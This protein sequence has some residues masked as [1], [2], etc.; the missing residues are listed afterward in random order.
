MSF[1]VLP[2]VLQDLVLDFAFK[3]TKKELDDDFETIRIIKSWDLHPIFVRNGSE[4]SGV[5]KTIRCKSTFLC[6][7]WKMSSQCL[8]CASFLSC[9][10]DLTFENAM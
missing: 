7:N 5:F 1:T 6:K 8:T 9:L 2:C 3:I 4:N 10:T